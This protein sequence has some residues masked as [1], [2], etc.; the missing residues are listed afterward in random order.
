MKDSQRILDLTHL[1]TITN[2][3]S[4]TA[5]ASIINRLN[6]GSQ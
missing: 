2:T 3:I 4:T 6:A 1:F 5:T